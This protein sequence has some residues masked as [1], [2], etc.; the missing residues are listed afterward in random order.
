MPF[1]F[2][3]SKRL[4][5]MKASLPLAVAALAACERFQRV[6]GPTSS[7][8]QVVATPDTVTLDPY[9]TR[10]F[11][12]YGRT[13]AGDS[14]P[15]AVR[16]VATA[17]TVTAGGLY[18][19]DT[20]PGTYLVTATATAAPVS[21]SATVKNRGLLKQV[22]VTPASASVLTGARLQFAAYGRRA[23]GD[24]VAVSV[25]WSATSGSISATGLYTAGLNAGTYQVTATQS[26]GTLAGN[27]AVTIGTVPVASVTVSPATVSI[28][29]GATQQFTAVTKDSAGNVLTGRVVTWST[30]SSSVATVSGSGLATGIA[31][32][33]VTITATSEGKSG[34]ASLTVSNVPVASVTVSPASATILVAATHQFTAVTKDS[35]GNILTGRLVTWSSSNTLVATVNGS[36]LATGIA[37]GSVTITA[38]SEGKSGTASLAVQPP[39]PPGT[40]PDP[41]LLPVASGQ[42]P[43]LAAYNALNVPGQPAGFSY[44]DPTTNVKVWKVTSSTVPAPNTGAGHDYADGPNQVS[45]GW[46]ANNNTH[47]LLIRGDGMAYYLVDFTRGVGFS[48]Y[49][50]LTVQP[51][52]DVAATFSNL[53]GQERIMYIMTNSQLLRYNTATMSVE[54][55]GYFPLNQGLQTWLQQDKNDIWFVGLVNATTAFAWNSQTNQ[56][57]TDSE[58]WLNEPRFERDGRY[59]ILTSGTGTVRVWDLSNNTLGSVQ[60]V[61]SYF[62]NAD[63]RGQWVHTNTNFSAPFGQIRQVVSGG[64]LFTPPATILLQSGGAGFH[65]AGNWIQSDADLGGNLNRQWSFISGFNYNNPSWESSLLWQEAIGVQRSDGSDQRLLLHH[66]DPQIP[67]V[68]FSLPFGMPSPDGKVVIFNSNMNGSGRYDLFIAEMPLR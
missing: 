27:A 32:G 22:I 43:N 2:K 5:L 24:S 1:T 18:T 44:N 15:V 28:L 39:P 12:A 37:A 53:A 42:A 41:T 68:Y 47:T 14:V 36:G 52:M 49:R 67:L 51:R 16:W 10:Q 17:G 65:Q 38:T 48:N 58:T 25:V 46:G 29:V 20:T 35:A 33:S 8:V 7:V 57:L 30:S 21:G 61:S 19:A 55:T 56:Y 59:V 54:N 45:L 60:S 4:A 66:Y 34:S 3:L 23:S 26:G 9:Q 13:Q 6:T 31:A 40:V 62:H 50:L 11:L 64:A 63:L